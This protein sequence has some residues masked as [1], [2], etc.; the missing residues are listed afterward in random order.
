MRSADWLLFRRCV[1]WGDGLWFVQ[2]CCWEGRSLCRDI[3]IDH[4]TGWVTTKDD[5]DV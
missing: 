4:V 1:P 2:W 5:A 3:V